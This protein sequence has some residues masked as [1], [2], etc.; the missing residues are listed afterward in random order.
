MRDRPSGATWLSG[1][2][3]FRAEG[4]GTSKAPC[5]QEEPGGQRGR[6]RVS[7]GQAMWGLQH[8]AANAQQ[9]PDIQGMNS[10]DQKG[11]RQ[12]PVEKLALRLGTG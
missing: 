3:V 7:W 6:H 1:R 4:T 10:E 9:G 2:K 12:V 5:V 8:Q 11:R